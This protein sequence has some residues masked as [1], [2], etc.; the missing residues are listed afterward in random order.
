M[1]LEQILAELSHV[2]FANQRDDIK[3]LNCMLL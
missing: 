1:Y 2:V 3:Y